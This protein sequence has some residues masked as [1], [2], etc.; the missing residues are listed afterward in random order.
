MRVLYIKEKI[1]T[2]PSL[3]P[4][5][6]ASERDVAILNDPKLQDRLDSLLSRS[7]FKMDVYFI[8]KEFE[9]NERTRDKTAKRMMLFGEKVF[10]SRSHASKL[11]VPIDSRLHFFSSPPDKKNLIFVTNTFDGLNAVSPWM[12]VHKYAHAVFYSSKTLWSTVSKEIVKLYTNIRDLY[13]ID[14]SPLNVN[15][16]RYTSVFFGQFLTM[17]SARDKTLQYY[18]KGLVGGTVNSQEWDIEMLTQSIISGIKFNTYPDVL[19]PTQSDLPPARADN[20]LLKR[21]NEE[22]RVLQSSIDSVVWSCMDRCRGKIIAYNED[23]Q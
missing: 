19:I 17:A 5:D 11:G 9:W 23:D 16:V 22:T 4:S 20:F 12:I 18:D 21:M 15:D 1:W 3:T 14:G 8:D 13:K 10:M 2:D 7:K 6:R